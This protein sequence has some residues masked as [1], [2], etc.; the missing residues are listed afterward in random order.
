MVSNGASL[1]PPGVRVDGDLPPPLEALLPEPLGDA[2]EPCVA[3]GRTEHRNGLP[4][5]RK[6]SVGCVL[7]PHNGV[8]ME[9][10]DDSVAH[11]RSQR[12]RHCLAPLASTTSASCKGQAEHH[13]YELSSPHPTEE[14]SRWVLPF[15]HR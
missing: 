14:P 2:Q 5:K 8:A 10:S 4:G 13:S 9:L 11:V 15:L 7:D 6:T 1:E 3:P 12:D